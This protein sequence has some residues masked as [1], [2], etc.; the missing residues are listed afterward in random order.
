M[1]DNP[2]K[3]KL[4]IE[5]CCNKNSDNYEE[6]QRLGEQLTAF[7]FKKYIERIVNA[8]TQSYKII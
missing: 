3:G 8:S 4:E 5:E 2:S 1:T 6:F 7:T